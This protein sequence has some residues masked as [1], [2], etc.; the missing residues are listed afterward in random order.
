M[1]LLH[2]DERDPAPT[3]TMPR[4]R[5]AAGGVDQDDAHGLRGRGEEMTATGELAIADEPQVRLMDQGRGVERLARLL[6][7]Q[8]LGGQL[9]QLIVDQGQELLG[10]L[11][12]A[13]L[14]GREDAGDVVHGRRSPGTGSPRPW[15]SA[16]TRH[17]GRLA[18]RPEMR[19]L[20][21][22]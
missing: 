20:P 11:R 15:P 1:D 8:P 16:S 22:D 3:A 14:D 9:A 6:V 4:G 5:L 13:G 17:P 2:I 10:D 7:R 12:V 19:W 21:Q 18:V